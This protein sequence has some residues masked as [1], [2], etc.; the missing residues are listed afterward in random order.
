MNATADPTRQF[1]RHTIATLAYRGD[2]I[3]RDAPDSFASFRAGETTRTPAQILA[4]IG[5]LLDDDSRPPRRGGAVAV[6]AAFRHF[7]PDPFP[8]TYVPQ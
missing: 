7:S 6:A 1:L 4:H 5:D 3:L 8:R 2:K